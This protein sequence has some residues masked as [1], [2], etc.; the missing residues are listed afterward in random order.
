VPSR[1]LPAAV[2]GGLRRV[3]PAPGF[4]RVRARD[5]ATRALPAARARPAPHSDS[6]RSARDSPPRRGTSGRGRAAPRSGTAPRR[7]LADGELVSGGRRSGLAAGANWPRAEPKTRKSR[8]GRCPLPWPGGPAAGRAQARNVRGN[9]GTWRSAAVISASCPRQSD[10]RPR[11]RAGS[12]T[13]RWVW[14]SQPTAVWFWLAR[15]ALLTAFPRLFGVFF[16]ARL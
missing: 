14:G 3:A 12:F 16:L 6:A 5:G 7:P 1:C 8:G 13:R 2:A 4:G 9:P 15:G 10:I 11:R